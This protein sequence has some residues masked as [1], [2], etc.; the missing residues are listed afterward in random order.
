M[1]SIMNAKINAISND[2]K[3]SAIQ[4]ERKEEN[5]KAILTFDKL[6]EVKAEYDALSDKVKENV[7]DEAK[8]KLTTYENAVK[9]ANLYVQLEDVIKY[10]DLTADEKAELKDLYK[11]IKAQIE[12][13]KTTEVD[14]VIETN[15]KFYFQEAGNLFKD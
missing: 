4:F 10:T 3:N 2:F 7:S 11:N 6:T 15:L 12:S 8:E 9:L 13:L 1:G 14:A 5:G